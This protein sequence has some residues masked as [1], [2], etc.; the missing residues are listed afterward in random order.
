MFICLLTGCGQ[1]DVKFPDAPSRVPTSGFSWKKLEGKNI[2]LWVQ[3]SPSVH[4]E[5]KNNCVNLNRKSN[6]GLVSQNV[7]RIFSINNK[8]LS[9]ISEVLEI[10]SDC[11]FSKIISARDGVERYILQPENSERASVEAVP[12]TCGGWGVGNSGIR[13]FELQNH[14]PDKVIFVEIGQEMPLFDEGSITLKD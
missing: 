14:N 10:P 7:I 13:Y 8:D 2:K 11:K 12:S 6:G 3:E 1:A 9:E 4:F 5:I